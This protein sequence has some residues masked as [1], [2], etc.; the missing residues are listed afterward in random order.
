MLIIYCKQCLPDKVVIGYGRRA[1]IDFP[2]NIHE[3]ALRNGYF[4]IG[5]NDWKTTFAEGDD[6]QTKA[7]IIAN[8]GNEF[9][10]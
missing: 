1:D 10:E 9:V 7:N 4:S 5:S 3:T 8:F 2:H 6:T